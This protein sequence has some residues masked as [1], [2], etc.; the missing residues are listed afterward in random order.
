MVRF[1][2]S[3]VALLLFSVAAVACSDAT[4]SGTEAATGGAVAEGMPGIIPVQHFFDNPEIAGAQIS[5]DGEWLSY[6]KAYEDKLNVFVRRFDSEEE[7]QITA[8]TV[9]PVTQY[10]W[11]ISGDK[12]LYVQDKGGNENFHVYAV[13]VDGTATPEA[14]DLTPFEGVRALIFAVPE[15]TPGQILVGLNQRNPQVFDAHWLD[16][17]TGD[18]RMV[19]ENPGRHGGYIL[20]NDLK[21]RVAV[22]QNMTGG[23]DIFARETEESEWQLV[24]SYPADE[25]IN[26]IRVHPDNQ[27]LYMS[28][29]AGDVD[30]ARLV[31]LN[32]ETGQVEEVES[33]PEGEVDFGQAVF[34]EVTDELIATVYV[35]DTVRIY[36]KNEEWGRDLARIRELHAGS[37][38]IGSSTLDERKMIIAFNDPTDPGATYLYDRDTG[39]GEFLFRPRPVLEG[40]GLA[41]MQPVSYQAR[42]GLTIHG[43]LSTP[44]GVEARN[45]PLILVVHGG[46]WARDSWGYQPEVQLLA[47]RGYA[48]L[49]IN[50][51]GS[52]G[53][54]KAF[55]NAAVKEWAGAMHN[56]L[57]DGVQWAIDQGIADPERVGIYG[58]S[59]GGYATLVG[60]TFTPEVFA[61]GLDYVGPSS[62]ITLINSFPAYWRP[63]LEGTFYRHVGNP[64]NLDDIE[65]MQARSPLKFVD[66]IEDAIMIVQGAN[67]PRVTQRESDQLAIA[68]RDRGIPVQYL[69]AENEGHGFANADN[70]MALYRSME[71]FFGQC[72]GGRVD[73]NVD[74]A[75]QAQIDRLTVDVEALELPEAEAD[76]Q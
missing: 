24:A 15:E 53:Y 72:L 62:L 7:I 66:Q 14:R 16:L 59:Y 38:G 67:D 34:S 11:A 39:E 74:P 33:D 25:N 26:P 58:G 69:L 2:L 37:P 51:R 49:Q 55:L 32:L 63:F 8:D 13:P 40:A 71:T 10:F 36:P 19:A 60:L 61:C 12:I 44:R 43:Y 17:E 46:P 54:G 65:H 45:L 29:D 21:V 28:S 35:A 42:D 57:V 18:L 76:T 22:G 56:D 41:D 70:R 30:L 1:R 27:R 50:Y 48:V 68:L 75:I 31:L 52:T 6:L 5:P 3:V 20:D 64:E 9:R 4:E 47:N 23:S 73:P